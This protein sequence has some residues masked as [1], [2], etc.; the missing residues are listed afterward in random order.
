MQDGLKGV[1]SL[2]PD[3]NVLASKLKSMVHTEREREPSI[4]E[5]DCEEKKRGVWTN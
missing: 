5:E 1:L 4:K 3:L 2:R